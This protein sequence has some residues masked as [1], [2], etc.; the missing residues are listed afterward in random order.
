MQGFSKKGGGECFVG[1]SPL[2]ITGFPLRELSTFIQ[3]VLY[4][5]RGLL[6][7]FSREFWAMGTFPLV[8]GFVTQGEPK[9][10]QRHPLPPPPS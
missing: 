7:S 10:K 1:V 8:Q 3:V 4:H 5:K 6:S 2:N 9:K